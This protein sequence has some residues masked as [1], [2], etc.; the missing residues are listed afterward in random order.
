[1]VT[2]ATPAPEVPSPVSS[3]G[4]IFGVLFNPKATFQSIV[5]RPTWVMPLLLFV[6][7]GV[8][9]TAII[10]QRVGWR[11]V[12]EKK[13]AESASAQKQM[14]SLTADQRE[15]A[16]ARQ[17]KYTPYFVYPINV[18]IPFVGT[19]VL[20]GI[21]LG[22]FNLIYG[23][24]IGFKTSMSIVA[25]AWV[26]GLL[27]ALLGILILFLKDPSTIDVQNLVASNPGA[28]MP[29]DSSK[30]LVALLSS[31]DIFS[32]WIMALM[33]LGYSAAEPKKLSFGKAFGTI[34]ALWF[35]VVLI[36]VGWA[37]MFS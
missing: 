35:I 6:V 8:L 36:K 20:A 28:L 17:V 4:R 29:D 9:I 5:T 26:P 27:S 25:Y 10:S 1:M 33:G 18:L 12:I 22:A 7:V 34:L 15:D 21:F 31:L 2:T 13:I 30:W 11:S 24:Q 3:F 32:F 37:A 16:I 19:L 14:D 23:A